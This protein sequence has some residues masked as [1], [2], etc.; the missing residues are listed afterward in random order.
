VHKCHSITIRIDRP[1]QNVIRFYTINK[2]N[3]LTIFSFCSVKYFF[4]NEKQQKKIWG[5]IFCLC[6]F[7]LQKQS[8]VSEELIKSKINKNGK[9]NTHTQQTTTTRQIGLAYQAI[10]K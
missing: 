4:Q 8:K 6:V 10:E 7:L 5:T 3:V 2:Y 1:K 9:Q